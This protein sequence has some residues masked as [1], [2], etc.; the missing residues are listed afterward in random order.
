M[1]VHFW[2]EDP[3]GIWTLSVTDNSNNGREHHR[4]KSK[5]GDLEDA[6]EAL[7]DDIEA[8]DDD[9]DSEHENIVDSQQPFKSSEEFQNN[10][11]KNDKYRKKNKKQPESNSESNGKM[12][13]KEKS[14]HPG[15]KSS[16]AK[17]EAAPPKHTQKMSKKLSKSNSS[18]EKV[19]P[20]DEDEEEEKEE[21][22]LVE[23]LL[24]ETK[25]TASPFGNV[26][27]EYNPQQYRYNPNLY[28]GQNTLSMPG[29]PVMGWS[30][31]SYGANSNVN[32]SQ[33]YPAQ[34]KISAVGNS[35]NSTLQNHSHPNESGNPHLNSTYTNEENT[36]LENVLKTVLTEAFS[37]FR[38]ESS[39]FRN[40]EE[41]LKSLEAV[42]HK[43]KTSDETVAS[44]LIKAFKQGK[45]ID[46]INNVLGVLENTKN[47]SKLSNSSFY[48]NSEVVSDVL[49]VLKDILTTNK[50]D[51]K[52]N[53]Y[54]A[55]ISKLLET[56]S[57]ST[58][59]LTEKLFND[60]EPKT[61]GKE[62]S[63]SVITDALKLIS[64]IFQR[65]KKPE[66]LKSSKI[67]ETAHLVELPKDVSILLKGPKG[68]VLLPY[69]SIENMISTD[70]KEIPS[71]LANK[72]TS[73][74][75]DTPSNVQTLT[76]EHSSAIQQSSTTENNAH[77]NTSDK[78]VHQ[79]PNDTALQK[80]EKLKL[81]EQSNANSHDSNSDKRNNSEN[82]H[83]L[84]SSRQKESQKYTA[85]KQQHSENEN[86]NGSHDSHYL[87]KDEDEKYE[88]VVGKEEYYHQREH[89]VNDDNLNRQ[90]KETEEGNGG[91]TIAIMKNGKK[92]GERRVN[93]EQASRYLDQHRE[94]E[95]DRIM[96][97]YSDNEDS[98]IRV[99]PPGSDVDVE[100]TIDKKTDDNRPVNEKPESPSVVKN[101]VGFDVTK[102]GNEETDD[103][104]PPHVVATP[105]SDETV[106]SQSENEPSPGPMFDEKSSEHSKKFQIRVDNDLVP[107]SVSY[108][109]GEKKTYSKK[110][111]HVKYGHKRPVKSQKDY[112]YDGDDDDEYGYND[113][114]PFIQI[115]DPS[116]LAQL[117]PPAIEHENDNFIQNL[118]GPV[119]PIMPDIENLPQAEEH[120]SLTSNQN[121]VDSQ[122]VDPQT[123][124]NS[125]VKRSNVN[126]LY[127][128]M[129]NI[130]EGKIPD[131]SE[132]SLD[133][134]ENRVRRSLDEDGD[135]NDVSLLREKRDKIVGDI[136]RYNR[137][138]V[139]KKSAILDEINVL[140][141]PVKNGIKDKTSIDHMFK[142]LY[143]VRGD[144]RSA[145]NKAVKLEDA[146]KRKLLNINRGSSSVLSIIKRVHD[147]ISAGNSK[148]LRKLG[149]DLAKLEA[150]G[151]I[152]TKPRN[153]GA[154]QSAVRTKVSHRPKTIEIKEDPDE[155]YKYGVDSSG[156][157]ENW[158]LRFYGTGP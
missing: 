151:F 83:L 19:T 29:G 121:T 9:K 2:G 3:K 140:K 137:P 32:V 96:T 91:Y 103:T 37:N 16:K 110:T 8:K 132:V 60:L 100:V 134:D 17:S 101:R 46:K 104:E 113:A 106:K 123:K 12:Q 25:P 80:G 93:T 116:Q 111:K 87:S 119:S 34:S 153:K 73:L 48:K 51:N 98:R 35:A 14:F 139:V 102:Y 30:S 142:Q 85:A 27:P 18:P 95:T 108:D 120:A 122:T 66:K 86:H 130:A 88:N 115:A 42:L 99:K 70:T 81:Q 131:F 38:A 141:E 117:P 63:S 90:G 49:K 26:P 135:I 68:K 128:Y 79:R 55:R 74:N 41:R 114:V 47:Q 15:I 44:S 107:K 144:K 78:P 77:Q 155:Y 36:M 53:K 20:P 82:N 1:S 94:E 72:E 61:D 147:D 136:D 65:K 105:Q 13:Q 28:A 23:E 84:D 31:N 7:Q 89:S 40:F 76:L 10:I 152:K 148:D 56:S 125:I 124:S 92:I 33:A 97:H 149:K 150:K 58:R 127:D 54:K 5:F 45:A 109:L 158:T 62:I 64:H 133:S 50:G 129:Q 21:E 24:L 75:S 67:K 126:E 69:S 112:Y 145:I 22:R 43:N 154:A 143:S 39:D 6:T 11:F 52:L 4:D 138:H 146:L 57:N 71:V 118:Y 59:Q 156:E 157:L